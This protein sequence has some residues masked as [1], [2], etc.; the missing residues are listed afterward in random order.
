MT[1]KNR[2]FVL[3]AV[4]IC[5]IAA[6]AGYV[7]SDD[8]ASRPKAAVGTASA[9]GPTASRSSAPKPS[10]PASSAPRPSPPA[11]TW[12]PADPA[13][14]D[15]CRT[16]LPSQA[17]DTLGLI[18]KGGPYPY[19]SDGIVFENR[20]NRLPRKTSGYYHEFTVVTPGSGDRGTRR[21]VTGDA[22]EQ[23]WTADH[24]GSFQEIDPR[25]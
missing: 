5:V 4:L 22:G 3:V 6:A 20:E 23:Y 18:A 2:L 11:A 14:A 9:A 12:V 21:V 19:R 10:A 15:V 24:Y 8:G 17:L 7:L 13:L 25:C 1:S 16:R